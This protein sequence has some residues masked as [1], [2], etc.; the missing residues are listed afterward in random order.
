M[1]DEF[2]VL[3]IAKSHYY[4]YFPIPLLFEILSQMRSEVTLL[5]IFSHTTALWNIVSNE[6][7]GLC[8]DYYVYTSISTTCK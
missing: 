7:W 5:S 1:I 6:K 4:Q 3:Q 8:L 2:C